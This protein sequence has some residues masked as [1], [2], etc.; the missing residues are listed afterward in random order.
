[1]TTPQD[2]PAKYTAWIS[3]GKNVFW[4]LGLIVIAALRFQ[5]LDN[6][7]VR[8]E[9]ENARLNK[10]FDRQV[11]QLATRFSDMEKQQNKQLIILTQLETLLRERTGSTKQ[12]N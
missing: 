4:V 9:E 7:V 12:I 6:R 10:V 11:E 8:L 3:L 5:N 1:M 2:M